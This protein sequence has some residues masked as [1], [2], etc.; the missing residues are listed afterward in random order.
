MKRIRGIL[1]EIWIYLEP[2]GASSR[3]FIGLYMMVTG[4]ARLITGNSPSMLN[5]FSSRLYGVL[6]VLA[7]LFLL[8]TTRMTWRCHWPGRIAAICCAACWLLVIVNAWPANAWVSISGGL[9][10]VLALANEVRI[11]EC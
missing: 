11:R 1:R 4:L 2:V 3:I 9:V 5:L 6:L 8:A 10:F 7:G